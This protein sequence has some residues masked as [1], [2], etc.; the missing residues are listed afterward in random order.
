M[1]KRN[2]IAIIVSFAAALGATLVPAGAQE[3]GGTVS[4]SNQSGRVSVKLE[5]GSRVAISNRYGRITIT[6]WDRDTVEAT[7]TSTKGA[8]A[9][10][11]DMTADPQARSTLTLAVVG[12]GRTGS[13]VYGFPAAMCIDTKTGAYV[14]CASVAP[15]PQ[16]VTP[17][18][19]TAPNPKP[20]TAA[21]V[22]RERSTQE[23]KDKIKEAAKNGVILV[24]MPTVVVE[25]PNVVVTTPQAAQPATPGARGAGTATGVWKGA[26]SG[27]G[28]GGG[29][30]AARAGGEDTSITLDVKVPRYAQLDAIEVRAGDLNISGIDGPVSVVS[31]SSNVTVNHVGALEVRT[32]SGNVNVEDV[33]GLVY[34]VASSSE[35]GVRRSNGDVRA[36]TINGNIDIQCVKGRVDASTSRGEI[37]LVNVGGDVEATTTDSGINFTGVIAPNGRYRLKSMEGQITMSVPESS[38]GFTANLMSY[39]SDAVTEFPVRTS[40]PSPDSRAMRRVEARHGDGQAQITL[41]SFSQSVHLA[42]LAPGAAS[43]CK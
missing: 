22:E 19:S 16:P 25:T 35:I 21:E 13:G 9:I 28:S 43:A 42:K 3:S 33:D 20:P 34:I 10:Q 39:N 12:R 41:D 15:R 1:K 38:P 17:K 23:M 32:R 36:T 2:F 7:A 37:R 8:E 29:V 30:G 26:G 14:P 6:G 24:P 40:T 31:G 4:L 18:P 11:I 27:S 5:R